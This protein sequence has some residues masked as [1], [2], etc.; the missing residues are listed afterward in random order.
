MAHTIGAKYT[1]VSGHT[2][3]IAPHMQKAGVKFLHI[4]VNPTCT[5]PDVPNLFRYRAPTVGRLK[6]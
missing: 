5:A 6:S 1:D 4:G 3:V 2:R